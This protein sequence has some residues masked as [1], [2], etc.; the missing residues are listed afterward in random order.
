MEWYV[1]NPSNTLDQ[2]GLPSNVQ[3]CD[4]G[5]ARCDADPLLGHCRFLV[6]VC[7][8][9]EDARLAACTPRGVER[10]KVLWPVPARARLPVV[11]RLLA[12]DRSAL[13]HAL[14]H[15]GNPADPVGGYTHAPPLDAGQRNFCSAPFPVD[16]L[17]GGARSERVTLLT[18]SFDALDSRKHVQLS[19]LTLSCRRPQRGR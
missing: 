11:Q 5:D 13:E 19:Q 3:R 17:V 9:N 12:A 8:N 6:V 14:Q 15:L 18:Q 16:V 2:F 7:L 4:D 1:V 10:V